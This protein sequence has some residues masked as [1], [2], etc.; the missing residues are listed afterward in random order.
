MRVSLR[1]FDKSDV[2]SFWTAAAIIL[3]TLSVLSLHSWQYHLLNCEQDCGESVLAIRSAEIFA[4]HGVTFGLLENMNDLSTP[5]I[6]THNVNL[7]GLALIGLEAIGVPWQLRLV[8]PLIVYGIGLAY[9]F[10]FVRRV[11]F[12]N[13]AGLFVV[14]IF[15]TVY[16]GMGAFATNALR[17]WH[18]FA[19][20][21]AAYHGFGMASGEKLALRNI[22][23]LAVGAIAAF[24][25]GYDFWIVCLSVVVCFVFFRMELL[26]WRAAFRRVVLVGILF[27]LPFVL[28][29]VHVASVMG[30]SYWWQDFIYSF[31]I[32]VPFGDRLV[33]IPPLDEIDAWY[34]SMQVMRPPAQ[35]GQ[36]LWQI[37]FTLRHM[38]AWITVPRW[39]LLSIFTLAF[40]FLV[41]LLPGTKSL[42]LHR[43]SQSS[44]VPMVCG[45]AIGLAVFAPFSFHVYLKHEFPLI[46]FPILLAKGLFLFWVCSWFATVRARSVKIGCAAAIGL[47]TV[48]AVFVHWNNSVNAEYP[49]FGW[50]KFF[51]SRDPGAFTLSTYVPVGYANPYLGLTRGPRSYLDVNRASAGER[52]ATPYW[53]YQPADYQLDFDRVLPR[54]SWTGWLR[55]LLGREVVRRSQW[56][57]V[58]DQPRPN[59]SRPPLT[60]EELI[61]SAPEYEVVE[62][63]DRGMGYV[64]L[65]RRNDAALLK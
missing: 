50:I 64:V 2:L 37:F 46:A 30:A 19:F 26:G 40:V 59:G 45:T 16:W 7:G 8:L 51:E 27:F 11:T 56:N 49:N 57:C 21:A 43:W 14:L 62:R 9:V 52:P 20:F 32:K 44:V 28:R 36:P 1:A 41:G 42:L 48:D 15:S 22:A 3:A 55:A 12:S 54:C 5:K 4:R 58:Y 25:C 29:Q 60:V 53:I 6:Y 17:A 47:F 24:G 61:R 33:R 63:S 18:L 34:Q 13:L 38:V 35:P 31:A 10:L 39:G 65:N 23:G